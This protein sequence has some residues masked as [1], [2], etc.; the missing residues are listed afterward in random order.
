M[1]LWKTALENI[2][3]ENLI[4]MHVEI[5]ASVLWDPDEE[6]LPIIHSMPHPLKCDNKLW[7][8]SPSYYYVITQTS[9][10]T[11][12]TKTSH[13]AKTC[14]FTSLSLAI[15]LSLAIITYILINDATTLLHMGLC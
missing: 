2:A 12:Q 9:G 8:V 14:A 15:N 1:F 10:G 11:P 6:N 4:A 5:G 7:E 13:L 3:Y